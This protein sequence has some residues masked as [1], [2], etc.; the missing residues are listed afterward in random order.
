MWHSRVQCVFHFY[1]WKRFTCSTMKAVTPGFCSQV[2][3]P[4]ARKIKLK[5]F[6][7]ACIWYDRAAVFISDELMMSRIP[8][9]SCYRLIRSDRK[10]VNRQ[11]LP[12]QMPTTR[13]KSSDFMKTS[14]WEVSLPYF[15]LT[16]TD[17]E[18]LTW[19]MHHF[20]H[21]TKAN[22][23]NKR[24]A[25]NYKTCAIPSQNKGCAWFLNIQTVIM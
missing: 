14:C 23:G 25:E 17:C 22:T 13:S 1:K 24:R 6:L 10:H 20:I 4:P 3:T 19:R 21:Q 11:H 12:L 18:L 5:G 9:R 15:L 7:Y 2:H 8:V 16:P